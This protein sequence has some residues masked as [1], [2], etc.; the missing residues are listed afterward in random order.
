MRTER[1]GTGE[2]PQFKL[3]S[4]YA[5]VMVNDYLLRIVFVPAMRTAEQCGYIC[6]LRSRTYLLLRLLIGVCH[7]EFR[8]RVARTSF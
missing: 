7:R 1:V 8:I 4:H 6:R 3:R 2:L 5:I